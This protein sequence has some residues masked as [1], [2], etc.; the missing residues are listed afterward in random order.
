[1]ACGGRVEAAERGG[2]QKPEDAVVATRDAVATRDGGL[3]A[4]LRGLF[5]PFGLV[6]RVCSRAWRLLAF[7]EPHMVTA[8]SAP[9]RPCRRK[10]LRRVTR[11]LL[12][13]LPRWV[14]SALGF[15][16]PRSIG[17]ALSPEIR[18]SPAK[19]DGKGSKRKQDDLDDDEE[20]EEDHP[21][22]VEALSKELVDDEGPA[23]DPDYEPS[24]VE[25][26]TDEYAS[27][28]N[29]ESDLEL[30][31]RGLVIEDVQTDAA[32]LPPTAE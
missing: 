19:P 21:S 30:S 8:V 3:R 12:S 22:W 23:E 1:M 13:V 29:T 25:T 7:Q 26:D 27:H 15:P 20:E 5:W 14:Q 9:P 28:N 2:E 10:R 31:G 4:L 16:G 11:A 6:V 32:P 24:S 17:V 18:S